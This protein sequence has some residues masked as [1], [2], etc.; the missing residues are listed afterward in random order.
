MCAARPAHPVLRDLNIW[1]KAQIRK[2]QEGSRKAYWTPYW[3]VICICA[4]WS[5]ATDRLCHTNMQST[6][7]GNGHLSSTI[8]IKSAEWHAKRTADYNKQYYQNA[9]TPASD[10]LT[11]CRDRPHCTN[12][13][14]P[15]LLIT[16]PLICVRG[17]NTQGRN[18]NICRYLTQVWTNETGARS[19]D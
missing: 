16:W 2:A 1:C 15:V 19:N 6:W 12:S 11:S 7:N 9:P 4:I 18:I 10:V 8:W 3:P 5:G 14:P 17:C 13:K